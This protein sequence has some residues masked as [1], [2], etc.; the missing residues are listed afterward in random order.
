MALIIQVVKG[1]WSTRST[2]EWKLE[3]W[4]NSFTTKIPK[5]FDLN[6][7][8]ICYFNRAILSQSIKTFQVGLE[9]DKFDC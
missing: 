5:E 8:L 6:K 3:T 4:D 1:T 7:N 2:L 9:S